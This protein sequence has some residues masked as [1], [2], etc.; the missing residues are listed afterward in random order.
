MYPIRVSNPAKVAAN[1]VVLSDVLP[2]GIAYVDSTP[3]AKVA[4]QKLSWSLGTLAGGAERSVA[5]TVKG[6]KTGSFVN[7]ADVVADD[8][9]K[10]AAKATTRII[11]PALV[12]TKTVPAEV[13][14]CDPISYMITVKNTGDAPAKNVV[15][16]DKF[17]DGMTRIGG[18][19][20]AEFILGTI[21]PGES[22]GRRVTMKASKTGEYVN[23]AT[24]TGA[25]GLK[26]TASS[27]TVVRAP[28]L[29][30]TKKAPKTR[31]V[32]RPVKYTITVTNNGDATAKNTVLVD[33]LPA[34]A[35]FV[36]ASAGGKMASGKVTWK[37]GSL[38]PKATATV[39]V[40]L[41]ATSRG[42]LR[43][44]ATA[45]AY[46]SKASAEASTL[47]KGIPAILLECVDVSDPIEVGKKV[48]YI[49]T[50]T[51]QGSAEGT[52]IVIKCTLPAEQEYVS[53]KADTKGTVAGKTITFAALKSL[54]PKAKTVYRVVTKGT[55]TGD[56]RFKVSLTSDQ[57]T[58]PAEETESTHIFADD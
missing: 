50:V 25:G 32:G 37:L 34:K 26:A 58:S 53:S 18:G 40:T 8:G 16:V 36:S 52:N 15:I 51:N 10:A 20:K 45:T 57:M 4:G 46:C 17:P 6:T 42:D 28:M 21:Q 2:A 55:K 54:A 19:S 38:A 14:L 5:V 13:L 29:A 44:Y 39:S 49:I 12:M 33:T 35:A 47:V 22:K 3:K 48:S 23:S 24:A 27:K 1:N 11:Q 56:T 43:S 30:V 41:K 7:V 9:L 31:F